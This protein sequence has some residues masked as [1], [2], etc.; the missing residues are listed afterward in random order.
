MDENMQ[1]ES[2]MFNLM[3]EITKT[4]EVRKADRAFLN[5]TPMK[6]KKL[7]RVRNEAEGI[8][9]DT[10]F[11]K[12]YKDALPISDGHK[13]IHGTELDTEMDDFIKYKEPKGLQY[14][15]REAQRKGNKAAGV[16]LES[17]Q[18]L[19]NDYF[20]EMEVNVKDYD[21]DDIKFNP[22]D[23]TITNG[24]Q[25]ITDKMNT[26]DISEVIRNN[27][28]QAAIDDITRRKE[29]MD[30]MKNLVNDLKNDPAIVSE[31]ALDRELEIA[32]V[33]SK[34][35]FAPTLFEGIMI[36]KTNLIKE[37]G[38]DLDSDHV[39]KK[40]FTES[41]KELT[42]ISVMEAFA[43][44]P[45]DIKEKNRLA[46]KYARMVMPSTVNIM[47]S[48]DG[49][50]GDNLE[51]MEEG[52]NMEMRR[53]FKAHIKSIKT[54]I[55]E[56]KKYMKANDHVS[57]AKSIAAAR[58]ELDIVNK[59]IDSLDASSVGSVVLGWLASDLPVMGR[60][61]V[62][63]LVPFVGFFVGLTTLVKRINVIID[64][65]KK[66][67]YTDTQDFN[68]YRNSIKLRLKE[69]SDI[70]RRTEDIINAGK[71]VNDNVPSPTG[72]KKQKRTSKKVK[73]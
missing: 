27:V 4:E 8:C 59:K 14:Y 51:L 10:I 71:E 23:E 20:I 42:K 28:K 65:S 46:D 53:V 19:L 5:S 16:L 67:G 68:M 29:Q 36:N 9:L 70:L 50:Y 15:V 21:V 57:A 12:I 34:K 37:A 17:V 63:C 6:Q 22:D 54:N 33:T 7:E 73:K 52:A 58:E 47:E 26:E 30:D 49:Y 55:K 39:T 31:E 66:R 13:L 45:I 56:M 44:E 38:T 61:L 35:V 64:D 43:A 32:G 3:D 2:K 60:T 24:L 41:V 18:A 40:A 1:G 62:A 72:V 11:H 48:V 69:Y 25:R